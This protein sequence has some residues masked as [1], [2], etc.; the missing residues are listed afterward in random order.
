LLLVSAYSYEANPVC[1]LL[2]AVNSGDS[3]E[4]HELILLAFDAGRDAVS[5]ERI[6]FC[7]CLLGASVESR[8]H[9]PD[10][11][12]LTWTTCFSFVL[13]G[14]HQGSWIQYRPKSRAAICVMADNNNNPIRA[15]VLEI[16]TT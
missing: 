10:Y 4:G 11:D 3:P 6:R 7:A 12:L 13:E 8:Q 5:R 9:Y 1:R 2:S 15:F 16:A 14:R